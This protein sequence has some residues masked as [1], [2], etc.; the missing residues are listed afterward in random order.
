MVRDR[1]DLWL[2]LAGREVEAWHG[3][4][5]RVLPPTNL[6]VYMAIHRML[7]GNKPKPKKKTNTQE[8]THT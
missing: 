8:G 3:D 5:S 7:H 6:P 2:Y 1:N 4:D